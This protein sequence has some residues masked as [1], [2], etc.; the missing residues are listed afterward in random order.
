MDPNGC[1]EVRIN[2]ITFGKNRDIWVGTDKGF[3]K[4]E[5]IR[6]KSFAKKD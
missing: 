4:L 3:F 1:G 6:W 5:N 2:A